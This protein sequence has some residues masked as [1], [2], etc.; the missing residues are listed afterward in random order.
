MYKVYLMLNFTNLLLELIIHYDLLCDYFTSDKTQRYEEE[1]L[2]DNKH[3]HSECNRD[4]RIKQNSKR[5]THL[6]QKPRLT[7]P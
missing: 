6:T 3:T 1:K 4:N 5:H 7:P 2:K